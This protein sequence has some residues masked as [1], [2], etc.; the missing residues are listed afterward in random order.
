M[1]VVNVLVVW[2]V[3]GMLPFNVKLALLPSVVVIILGGAAPG[4]STNVIGVAP[5]AATSWR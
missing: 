5:P 2:L 4:V 3:T 1:T